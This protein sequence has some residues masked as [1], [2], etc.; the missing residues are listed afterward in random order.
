MKILQILPQLTVGGVETGTVDLARY[1]KRRGIPSA[2]VSTGG[3]LVASLEAEGI[4]HT[5]LPVAS[6]AFWV[7]FGAARAL[8]RIIVRE[9]IDIVHARSRVPAWVAFMATRGTDAILITTAHGRYS[10][11]PFSPMMGWGKF[12]IVPS[13]VIGRYMMRTFRVPRENIRLIP[14]SVDLERYR[15]RGTSGERQKGGV[16]IGVIGR[17]SPVKGHVHFLKALA[18]VRRALPE[19]RAWFVGDVSP[20]KDNYKEDLLVWCRRLG[21]GRAVTFCGNRKDIPEILAQLDCL[22][23]PSVVEESFGRVI[24]EAQAVGVPVVASRIGGISE[25]VADGEDGLLVDPRDHEGLAAAMLRFFTDSTLLERCVVNG[26]RKVEE[27]Y[28]LE[29]MG[30]STLAVY[31]EA[32]RSP[33]LLVIKI[34][35][36]GDAVLVMPSL[37]ALR[38]RYPSAHI[39]VLTGVE[40]HEVFRR[41][42]FIDDLIVCDLKG[43]HGGVRGLLRLGKDLLRRRFDSVVDF[44]NNKKS[45][46]LGYL[47]Y[48]AK[49]Y[50]YDNRKWGFLLNRKVLDSRV[51]M[52]PVRHQFE[53]LKLMGIAYGGEALELWPS[54]QDRASVRE[55]VARA[56]QEGRPLVGLNIGAS[57]RW[58]TKRWPE[59]YFAELCA[60]L[61][62]R[63]MDVV[64]TGSRA[65]AS[66]A[67]KILRQTK[68]RPLCVVARTTFLQLA[69][70]MESLAVFVTADS[71][72][73]HVAA[74]MKIPFVALFGPTDPKR[75]VPAGAQC[76]V[77]QKDCRP[78]YK[79]TCP[80]KI[81]F[82]MKAIKPED[83]LA[84]VDELMKEKSS[85]VR[86]VTT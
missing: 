34:G 21:L 60:R 61:E 56:G 10:R 5:R 38:K 27:R 74:A 59:E 42:P 46:L 7:M 4:A 25:V 66:R 17:L 13:A 16:L 26:R 49:R 6:K 52:D 33:R 48:A 71:A 14:R 31:E 85:D 1:L 20:G 12:T 72:P 9:G 8:R 75:H 32:W 15:F 84:A 43:R 37:R 55:L 82:C 76:V 2:V 28:A 40:A 64:L 63:G 22:V 79:D 78:C 24:I 51:P 57:P 83:V 80:R 44:Q 18:L 19:A 36:L 45:H 65:D 47:S 39:T 41:C 53:V 54:A 35:A 29:R 86:R 81:F 77:L 73:M 50:G 30:A 3:P 70:L 11:H 67:Q 68:A 69:A 58:H 23:M 62:A